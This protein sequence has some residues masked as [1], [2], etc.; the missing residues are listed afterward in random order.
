LK[1]I[2]CLL[3]EVFISLLFWSFCWRIGA[4]ISSL[5][6]L[7]YGLYEILELLELVMFGILEWL[8]VGGNLITDKFILI[9][10]SRY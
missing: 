9:I 1:V 4:V 10:V 3:E 8:P 5:L 7:N 6:L 2:T